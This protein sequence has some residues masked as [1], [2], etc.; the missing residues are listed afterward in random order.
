MKHRYLF[1]NHD[2]RAFHRMR[3]RAAGAVGAVADC[4][5][6]GLRIQRGLRAGMLGHAVQELGEDRAG[7]AACAVDGIVADPL[8]QLADVP[9]A[10]T[11]RAVEHAAEGESEIVAG[12]AIGDREDIDL[13][14]S[15]AGGDD[16]VRASNQRAAQGRG[17][18]WGCGV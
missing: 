13:V 14:E 10:A 9:A 1:F 8:Q 17:G 16:P 7:I 12:V 18:K 3:E 11:Q 2:D 5:G 6:Q 4:S 15:V